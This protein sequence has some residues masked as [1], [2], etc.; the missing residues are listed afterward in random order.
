MRAVNDAVEDRVTGV[1]NDL[2]P[3]IHRNL[4]GDQQ[5][6]AVVAVIDDLEQIAALLGPKRLRPPVVDDQQ[7]DAFERG[8]EARQAA[9]AARWVRSPNRRLARL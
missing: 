3:A 9:L 1:G 6:A 5:R 4:A 7:P 8:Q 2:M